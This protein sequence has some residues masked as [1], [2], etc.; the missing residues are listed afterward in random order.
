MMSITFFFLFRVNS[1]KKSITLKNRKAI[2]WI[3]RIVQGLEK[4][5]LRQFKIRLI[6]VNF[7]KLVVP[8]PNFS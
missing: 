6:V 4:E 8:L 3:D 7:G 1:D 5:G 2:P